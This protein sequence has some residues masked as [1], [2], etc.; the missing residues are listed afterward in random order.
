[1]EALQPQQRQQAETVLL[2][3]DRED[4]PMVH[5]MQPQ[6]ETPV[7]EGEAEGKVPALQRVVEK[8]K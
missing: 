8:G 7:L 1:M 5:L 3:A 4:L 2:R 6:V